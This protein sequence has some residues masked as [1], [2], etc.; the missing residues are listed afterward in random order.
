MANF[1]Y[2]HGFLSSPNSYKAQVTQR[3]LSQHRDDISYFCPELSAHPK[4]TKTILLDLLEPLDS[5]ETFVVGSSLGGFWATYLI[6]QGFAEKAVLINPSV[7]PQVRMLEFINKPL[8]SYSG[9]KT[10][11]LGKT[12]MLDFSAYSPK[13]LNDPSKYWLL[14]QKGDQTLD[15]NHGVEFYA[16]A[17][18]TI[19]NGGNHSFA[20]YDN[21]ISDILDFFGLEVRCLI[22]Y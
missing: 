20:G 3:W 4:E 22:P 2:L 21:Y 17:K 16:G 9:D 18:Q 14:S 8:K 11:Q 19:E 15:Y 12:D 10:Y 13:S 6:E 5:R 7:R 1:I